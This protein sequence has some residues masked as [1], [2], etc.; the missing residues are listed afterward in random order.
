MF[1]VREPALAYGKKKL[2]EEEFREWR[3]QQEGKYEYFQGEVFA[4]GRNSVIHNTIVVNLI[5]ILKTKLK[6][7]PCQPFNGDQSIYIPSNTLYTLPDVS[8][9]CGAPQTL[10]NNEIDVLNPTLLAEVLSPST[11]NYDK[12]DKFSLYKEISSLKEYLIIDSKAVFVESHWLNGNNNWESHIYK[13]LEEKL[14]LSSLGIYIPI[15]EI[16][17]GTALSSL[18]P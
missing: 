1:E 4:M 18:N 12:G 2:T 14:Y 15:S 7:K 13:N 9:V 11:R 6:G 8:V 10:D 5:A 16:Y 3:Q 17:E